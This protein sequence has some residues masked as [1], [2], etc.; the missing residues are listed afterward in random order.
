MGFWED[1]C[2]SFVNSIIMPAKL[3][4]ALHELP[5]L[6]NFSCVCADVPVPLNVD[7]HTVSR[8]V[9]RFDET[10]SVDPTDIK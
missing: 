4:V 9:S 6:L 1:Y 7:P 5:K 3:A 8:I 10:G 2:F